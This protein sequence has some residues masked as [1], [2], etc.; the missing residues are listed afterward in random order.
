MD[1]VGISDVAIDRTG[2]V[3]QWTVGQGLP[4]VAGGMGMRSLAQKNLYRKKF[5]GPLPE[6]TRRSALTP[7]GATAIGVGLPA[8][9]VSGMATSEYA[10]QWTGPNAVPFDWSQVSFW[11]WMDLNATMAW[12]SMPFGTVGW[13]LPTGEMILMNAKDGTDSIHPVVTT[14]RKGYG[15]DAFWQGTTAGLDFLDPDPAVHAITFHGT[16]Y[17]QTFGIGESPFDQAEPEEVVVMDPK[18]GIPMITTH[19][20]YARWITVAL[21]RAAAP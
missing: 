20:A 10:R 1:Q 3:V 7:G 21:S 18:E 13:L 19:D 5:I 11:D 4:M 9:S 15:W 12:D 8:L 2:D 14:A 16:N 6:G 17:K